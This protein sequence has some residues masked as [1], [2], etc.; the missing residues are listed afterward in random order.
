MT[1]AE[2]FCWQPADR[3]PPAQIDLLWAV[4]CSDGQVS[5]WGK[6]AWHPQLGWRSGHHALQAEP[7]HWM[8]FPGLLETQKLQETLKNIF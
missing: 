5:R 7:T 6:A 2:L 4:F 8:L 3:V 1:E